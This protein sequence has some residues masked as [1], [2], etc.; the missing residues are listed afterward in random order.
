MCCP[1]CEADTPEKVKFCIEC[2]ATLRLCC[3]QCRADVQPGAEFGDER[4][5]SL[6]GQTPMSLPAHPPISLD[7]TPT[8]L[9][10]KTL[11][12]SATIKGERKPVTVLFADPKGSMMLLADRDPE[13]PRQVL[14]EVAALHQVLER[15]GAS[16][17]VRL[18]EIFQDTVPAPLALLDALTP[19]SPFLA[20][21]PAQ[22]RPHT[23]EA[24]TRMLLRESPAQPLLLACEDLHWIDSG[25]QELL[26]G[27]IDSLPTAPVGLLVN[28]RPEYHHRWDSKTFYTQLRLDPLSPV[29]AINS[30]RHCS[31]MPPVWWSSH[32]S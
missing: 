12:S 9:A 20:L 1:R 13:E 18:E 6:T 15:A 26:D 27:L 16:Q 21:D 24:L 22:R 19:D 3:L 17:V 14:D 8:H 29:R 32:N 10:E 4:G 5:T 2:G 30:C 23:L 31:G 7:Y 28:D 11:T 25:T